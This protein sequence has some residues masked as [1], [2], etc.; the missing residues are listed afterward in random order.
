[1]GIGDA[2]PRLHAVVSQR[3]L[4]DAD[5][6]VLEDRGMSPEAQVLLSGTLTFGV[7]LGLALRELV[8]LRRGTGGSSKPDRKPDAPRPPA[9]QP[10]GTRPL[11]DCL[12]P[13]PLLVSGRQPSEVEH[14]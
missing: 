8:A 4:F 7:P 13:K 6:T 11:P 12:I 3:T 2:A 14:A 9:P 5:G 1:M 10:V